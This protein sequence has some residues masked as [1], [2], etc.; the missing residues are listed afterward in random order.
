MILLGLLLFLVLLSFRFIFVAFHNIFFASGTWTFNYSD[1]LIR[2]FPERFWFD[3]FIAVG[4]VT[5]LG[6]LALGLLFG[7][8]SG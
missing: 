7:R 3:V 8:K 6:G 4:G 1:T 2:L 5:L